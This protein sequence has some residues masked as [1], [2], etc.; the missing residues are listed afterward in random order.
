[1]PHTRSTRTPA[2]AAPPHLARCTGLGLLVLAAACTRAGRDEGGDPAAQ[3]TTLAARC[4]AAVTRAAPASERASAW[5]FAPDLRIGNEDTHPL[6][7]VM[8]AAWDPRRG[9]LYVLDGSNS[10]VSAYDQRGRWIAAFGRRGLG[11]GEFEELGP[12]HGV[13]PVYNQ[14]AV[15]GG[16]VAV[17]E[18]DLLHLFDAQG[19]FLARLRTGVEQAGP[20]GV[21]QLAAISDS[22]LL[23]PQTG[24]MRLDAEDREVRTSLRLVRASL[25][26]AALDTAEFGRLRNNLYRM[27]PFQRIPP[28]DPFLDLY[29]RTWD[30]IPSGVVAATSQ[31]QHGVCFTD[32][33]GGVVAAWRVDEPPIAVDARERARVIEARTRTAGPVMPMT[34]QR[35]EDLYKAWP[36]TIPPY[37][38]LALGPD[39]VAWAERRR[40][41]GSR[42]V[43]LFHPRMGY[44]GSLQAPGGRL[45]LAFSPG[46]VFVVEEQTPERVTAQNYF[47]GLR[48]W[49]RHPP[50]AENPGSRPGS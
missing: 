29:N 20:H 13:R 9:V 46:C 1:M 35:W 50:A 21:R 8:G 11:P 4:E 18:L 23:F 3:G 32:R 36:A 17:M 24:A 38:D 14:I 37:A 33:S 12:G 28:G 41:D 47:Y 2:A 42:V 49:C 30:A 10:R 16:N 39:S 7:R 40:R 6:G 27:P 43:D 48:R 22:T 5:S 15:V 34:G 44:L 45:P 26:G 25:R 19:R 31:F